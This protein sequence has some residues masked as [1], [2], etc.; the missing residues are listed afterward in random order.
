MPGRYLHRLLIPL[1]LCALCSCGGSGDYAD[2]AAAALSP[3][4]G[5]PTP[6]E[7]LRNSSVDDTDRFLF[8]SQFQPE[9]VNLVA[10]NR[11]GYGSGGTICMITASSPL[12]SMA[13]MISFSS[14]A[15]P[16]LPAMSSS[17]PPSAVNSSGSAA[18]CDVTSC[19]SHSMK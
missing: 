4:A 11:S 10:T 8:G 12:R 6:E 16:W 19:E 9:P 5:L 7:I 14:S 3:L 1:I 18:A 15:A 2:P 17:T 13:K